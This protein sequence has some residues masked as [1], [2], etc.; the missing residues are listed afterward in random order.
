[1][2]VAPVATSDWTGFYAGGQLGFGNLT[3]DMSA[4][5][6]SAEIIDGSGALFGVHA[7]YRRDFGRLVLGAELD[8]DLA[9]VDLDVNP[10]IPAP[11]D[12]LGSLDSIARAKLSLGY[13][14][15]RVLP[16]VT[17]GVAR[18]SF[19]YDD[20]ELAASL[21]DTATGHF[22]GLGAAFA[23]ND[24]FTVGIEALRHSFDGPGVNGDVEGELETNINTISLRGSWRF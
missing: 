17:A 8:W 1:V 21:N 7:G 22:I 20:P 5:D 19:S 3:M 4:D 18:A 15:G 2:P 14:A 23:V 12:T 6:E 24:R 9:S 16:Y 10:G 11:T 13:D